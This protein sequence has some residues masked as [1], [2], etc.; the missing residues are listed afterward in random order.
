MSN[1]DDSK[2]N[3]KEPRIIAPPF[4]PD[5]DQPNDADVYFVGW[6][7]EVNQYEHV[8]QGSIDLD[9]YVTRTDDRGETYG[10]VQVLAGGDEAQFEAQLRTNA[11]GD[12][13]YAVWQ[14]RT[15]KDVVD[16]IFVAGDVACVPDFNEDG[17]LDVLDF[18]AFQIAF[19]SGDL[20]ADVNGDGVL[21]VLDFVGFQ[22]LFVA[23]C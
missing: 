7:T 8:S 5:P 12:D 4:S 19:T 22:A 16:T 23:G 1:I 10:P 2:I 14:E 13:L 3:V 11:A 6:G 21:D 20:R 15:P 18:V 9:I 17:T